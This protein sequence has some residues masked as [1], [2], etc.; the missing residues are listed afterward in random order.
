LITGLKVPQI[1]KL[2]HRSEIPF[3]KFG[4]RLIFSRKE[5]LQWV[6]YKT[7]IPTKKMSVED[8]IS[9]SAIARERRVSK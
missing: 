3:K 9:H 2:T 4:K 7:L 5:I 6:E 1:Y 8:S